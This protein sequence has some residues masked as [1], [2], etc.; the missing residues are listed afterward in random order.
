MKQKALLSVIYSGRE[1]YRTTYKDSIIIIWAVPK[2][3]ETLNSS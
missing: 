3:T 1:C 2:V